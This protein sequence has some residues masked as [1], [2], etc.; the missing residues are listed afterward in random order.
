MKCEKCGS[1][2]LVPITPYLNLCL[3]CGHEMA[4]EEELNKHIEKVRKLANVEVGFRGGKQ[5]KN[6]FCTVPNKIK[7]KICTDTP[8]WEQRRKI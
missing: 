3:S 1:E 5:A 8:E 7:E 2:A 6:G 4:N